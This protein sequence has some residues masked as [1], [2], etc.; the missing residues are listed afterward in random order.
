VLN[1]IHRDR[2]PGLLWDR[3]LLQGSI[4]AMTWSFGLATSS[5]GLAK[6]GN[7]GAKTR[8]SVLASN[9]VG[10]LVLSKMTCQGMIMM[11]LEDAE[12]EIINIWYIDKV[13]LA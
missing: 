2:I 12:L 1:E 3:K 8:P 9:E 4:R 11:L 5:A 10:G 6:L 7:I 13:V